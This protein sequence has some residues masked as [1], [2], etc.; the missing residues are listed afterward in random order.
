MLLIGSC[1]YS[2]PPSEADK[3]Q[4]KGPARKEDKTNKVNILIFFV[5][6]MADHSVPEVQDRLDAFGLDAGLVESPLYQMPDA[7]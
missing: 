7:E 5:F 3:K 2:D 4:T 1:S 6:W